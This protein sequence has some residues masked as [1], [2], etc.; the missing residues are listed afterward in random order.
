MEYKTNLSVRVLY[1][2]EVT[3]VKVFIFHFL[4]L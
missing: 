2:L 3:I 4:P 1:R